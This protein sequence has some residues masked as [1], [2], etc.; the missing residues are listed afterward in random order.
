MMRRMGLPRTQT[1]SSTL[2]AQGPS[3]G[4]AFLNEGVQHGTAPSTVSGGLTLKDVLLHD[5]GAAPLLAGFL[6]E[7]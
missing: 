3:G 5:K 6:V 4:L 7:G 2:D 1:L